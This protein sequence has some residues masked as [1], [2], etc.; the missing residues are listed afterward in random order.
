MQVK[1]AIVVAT[2]LSCQLVA[3]TIVENFVESANSAIDGPADNSETPVQMSDSGL[4][5]GGYS[6]GWLNQSEPLQIQYSVRLSFRQSCG[7][8][9]YAYT[10]FNDVVKELGLIRFEI[11]RA[12]VSRDLRFMI[13]AGSGQWFVSDQVVEI[14]VTP[15]DSFVRYEVDVEDWTWMPVI[16]GAMTLDGLRGD[17]E[18]ALQLGAGGM[19]VSAGVDGGGLYVE[20][21]GGGVVSFHGITWSDRTSIGKYRDDHFAYADDTVLNRVWKASPGD[22]GGTTISLETFDG[23]MRFDYSHAHLNGQSSVAY[24]FDSSDWTAYEQGV[25][26]VTVRGDPGN[27]SGLL[28]ITCDDAENSITVT[29]P[30]PEVLVH[31]QWIR[32][33]FPLVLFHGI[34]WTSVSKLSIT[35]SETSNSSGT[36]WI[37]DVMLLLDDYCPAWRRVAADFNHD[38]RVDIEDVISVAQDWLCKDFVVSARPVVQEPAVHYDFEECSGFVAADSSGNGCDAVVDSEHSEFRVNSDISGSLALQL[39]GTVRL[40]L[41]DSVFASISNTYTIAFWTTAAGDAVEFLTGTPAAVNSLHNKD[42]ACGSIEPSGGSPWI[43]CVLVKDSNYLFI[44]VNGILKG[45]QDT[46]G[47][48]EA[49]SFGPTLISMTGAD[50]DGTVLLDD[51]RIY[52]TALCHEEI[53][54]L[55]AD[56]GGS[57]LQPVSPLYTSA[58]LIRDGRVDLNDLA[59]LAK[60]IP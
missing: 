53:V 23:A 52:A 59:E 40:I 55:F 47:G 16:N 54:Q 21:A 28:S 58:D 39:D 24:A 29:C 49:G 7:P 46:D 20:G 22:A 12:T 30:Y 44:Y 42:Y 48:I 38:C 11:E 36:L 33:P 50:S 60:M 27:G 17:D 41:P 34:D 56:S 25:L 14:P 13:R 32:C 18:A 6:S 26:S 8:G 4:V 37:D 3:E 19:V 51:L 43:H 9:S 15:G 2:C 31:P 45:R 10:I 57:V 35:V 5:W 1:T